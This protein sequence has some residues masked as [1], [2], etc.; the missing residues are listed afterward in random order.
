MERYEGPRTPFEV[1]CAHCKVT[2]AAGTKKCIHCGQRLGKPGMPAIGSGAAVQE[3]EPEGGLDAANPLRR[4]GG[5]SLWV[6]IAV[7]AALARMCGEGG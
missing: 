6:L 7:G 5:I 2:F 1:Y 3:V 4:A